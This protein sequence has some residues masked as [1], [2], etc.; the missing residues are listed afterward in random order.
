MS[1][2][3][4]FFFH[5]ASILKVKMS[6]SALII[7][8]VWK[9]AHPCV[10]KPARRG[11]IC[12]ETRSDL[13]ACSY[14]FLNLKPGCRSGVFLRS[15][16]ASPPLVSTAMARPAP[17][18]FSLSKSMEDM[19]TCSPHSNETREIKKMERI[20]IVWWDKRNDAAAPPWS[21][22]C[23]LPCWQRVQTKPF[24][25]SGTPSS[26]VTPTSL[27]GLTPPSS[28]MGAYQGAFILQPGA[29]RSYGSLRFSLSFSLDTCWTGM[30]GRG[31]RGVDGT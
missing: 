30:F 21:P 29:A 31:E 10:N 11:Q 12:T 4:S 13:H 17:D 3:F 9:R 28:T 2:F 23:S 20:P 15:P 19:L 6:K 26:A 16:C 27:R 5:L 22:S 14:R 8:W 1:L 24:Y 7:W 25:I 18:I